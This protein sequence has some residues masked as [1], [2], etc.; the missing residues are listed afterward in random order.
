MLHIKLFVSWDD[1]VE[2]LI[3]PAV[4]LGLPNLKPTTRYPDNDKADI[5]GP[6]VIQY[7]EGT[8]GDQQG[9]LWGPAGE[10]LIAFASG[11]SATLVANWIWDAIKRNP[12]PTIV[13]VDRVTVEFEEGAIKRL[14]MERIRAATDASAE[15]SN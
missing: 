12:K 10:F 9:G 8:S 2:K 1:H 7:I 15:N 3:S 6:A 11:V 4:F 5:P 14:I 13:S